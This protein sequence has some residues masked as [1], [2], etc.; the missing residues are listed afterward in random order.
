MMM[1]KSYIVIHLL[2]VIMLI[3]AV[4]A[5]AAQEKQKTGY[6]DDTMITAKIKSELASDNFLKSTEIGVKTE[7][8]VVQLSGFVDSQK[9][10]DR[11]GQIARS[12][13]GVKSV[14]NDLIVQREQD[15]KDKSKDKNKDQGQDMSENRDSMPNSK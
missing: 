1:K 6:M 15:Q 12:I 9:A 13:K 14:K 8:G 5:W 10:I 7:D 2:A 3:V 4:N 11:A